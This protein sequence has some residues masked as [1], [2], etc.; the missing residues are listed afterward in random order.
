MDPVI[1]KGDPYGKTPDTIGTIPLGISTVHVTSAV[2]PANGSVVFRIDTTPQYPA[3]GLWNFV[4]TP[5]VDGMT[6]AD[7]FPYGSTAITYAASMTVSGFD[8][9]SNLGR[10]SGRRSYI[11]HFQNRTGTPRTIYIWFKAFLQTGLSSGDIG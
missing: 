8:D 9:V 6:A 3:T 11:I 7:I 1:K 4:W 10:V 5:F 2:A